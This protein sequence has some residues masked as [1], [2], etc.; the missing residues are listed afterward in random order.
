MNRFLTI[1]AAAATAA[2]P[3]HAHPGG[4]PPR[5]YVANQAA[6]KVTVI[7]PVGDSVLTTVDLTTLGFSPH[8]KPHFVAVEPDGS[9]WYVSLVG[10]NAVVKLDR[11]NHVVGKATMETPGL[12]AL[13]PHSDRLIATRSMSAVRA[14]S[15]IGVIHRSDMS[16]DE[17]EVV[18]PRPHAVALSADGRYAYVGSLGTNQIAV[19]DVQKD[20][21]DVVD[22]PGDTNRVMVQFAVSPDGRTLA[23][24]AQLT[25][26]LLAF[27]LANPARPALRRTV[28]VG[29]WPWH[30]AF[31]P[32]GAE[33]WVPNQQSNDV[34][35]VDAASWKVLLTLRDSGFA[36]PHG[37]AITPNGQV[38]IS[39]HNTGKTMDMGGVGMAAGSTDRPGHVVVID[40][41]HHRVLRTL[42]TAPDGAG[43]GSGGTE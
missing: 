33:L 19:Y 8:A 20:R 35:I 15:R 12:L 21:A 5:V 2:A 34:S 29:I 24:T 27:D 7:D 30:V 39:N 3:A 23:A 11:N 13:D 17:V 10:D 18:V 40:D 9:Y 41:V 42:D 22:V 14:P 31:S 26:E 28:R 1:W 25:G 38:F 43:M 36:Q 32:D 16:I 4:T 37:I 6:A